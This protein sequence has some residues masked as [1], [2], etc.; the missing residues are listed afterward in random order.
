MT[1]A[2]TSSEI[3]QILFSLRS[4]LIVVS[5]VGG[6]LSIETLIC[7]TAI[8]LA[9]VRKEIAACVQIDILGITSNFS[10]L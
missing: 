9:K 2:S 8:G 3:M 6:K 7:F 4:R 1:R 10:L 5:P